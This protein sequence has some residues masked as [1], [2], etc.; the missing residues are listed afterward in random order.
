VMCAVHIRRRR[1][2]ALRRD[3]V[4][5]IPSR[6]AVR[7]GG[8]SYGGQH[9]APLPN[10]QPARG[11]A[12]LWCG[13][14]VVRARGTWP[15]LWTR[16][17]PTSLCGSNSPSAWRLPILWRTEL[18]NIGAARFHRARGGASTRRAAAPLLSLH[19]LRS[20][21]RISVRSIFCAQARGVAHASASAST[22]SA[23]RARKS[24]TSSTRPQRHAHP[25]GVLSSSVSRTSS[26]A[27]AS[28]RIVASCT[29]TP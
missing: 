13:T 8:R 21:S 29:P 9:F 1:L 19:V 17:G 26:R 16:S 6:H 18:T 7:G 2:P 14:V 15:F 24:V 12:V 5:G 3:R 20:S 27:P 22:G 25:S 28:S 10:A 4:S 23:P 11:R